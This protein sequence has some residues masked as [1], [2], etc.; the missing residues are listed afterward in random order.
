M[1]HIFNPEHF[2]KLDSPERKKSL[3]PAEIINLLSKNSDSIIAD[4]GC[5][6]GYFS[7]PFAAHY[8]L[9][10]AI[11]ISEIMVNEF[12]N[13]TC[14]ENI[15][16]SLGDFDELLDDNSV[17]VFFTSTVIHEVDDLLDFTKKAVSKLTTSGTIAYIDFIKQNSK[18]GPPEHKRIASE[19]VENMYTSFGL[20]SIVTYNIHNEFYLVMGTK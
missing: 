1:T 5:G 18:M 20:H 19:T 12:K 15:R 8:K 17:D 6:V 14:L 9:I 3:P 16:I 7:I 2:K 10:H 13:R 4:V 11:D